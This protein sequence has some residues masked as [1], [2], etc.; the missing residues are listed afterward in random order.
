MGKFLHPFS[1]NEPTRGLRRW[2]VN[3]DVNFNEWRVPIPDA[4]NWH[5]GIFPELNGTDLLLGEELIGHR[6]EG[7]HFTTGAG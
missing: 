5:F 7:G 6:P 1:E 3:V 4:Q 2:D